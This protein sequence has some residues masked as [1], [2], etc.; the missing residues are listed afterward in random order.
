MTS[1]SASDIA[2]RHIRQARTERGWTV[3]ELAD[4]C[5]KAGAPQITHTVITNL[6]TRR[7]GTREI[8]LDET[9]VLARV[10]G[11]PPL[12][13]M[14]P[15]DAGETLEI[16]PGDEMGAPE[17]VQWIA[18]DVLSDL[19]RVTSL[20]AERYTGEILRRGSQGGILTTIRQ[21]AVAA[22]RIAE[23]DGQLLSS[24]FREKY[25]D[26]A[27]AAG[28]YLPVMADRLMHLATRMEAL[29]YDP[30]GLESVREILVRRGLPSTLAEWRERAAD[31]PGEDPE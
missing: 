31:D 9:L 1:L 11:V 19:L 30:P 20:P 15:L 25:P 5:A 18:D 23:Y 4:R 13:L 22:R 10:L 16:V 27:A 24:A 3:R 17:A 21:I 14:V 12:Q 28:D 2:G 26:S 7:R 29:G 6:E 8:T